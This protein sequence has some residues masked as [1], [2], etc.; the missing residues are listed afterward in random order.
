M[1]KLALPKMNLYYR[2]KMK[3]KKGID[4]TECPLFLHSVIFNF[5]E[6]NDEK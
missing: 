5:V 3:R 2:R 4:L 6:I 1:K